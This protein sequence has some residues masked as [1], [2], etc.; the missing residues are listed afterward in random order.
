MPPERSLTDHKAL[1]RRGRQHGRAGETLRSAWGTVVIATVVV[2]ASQWPTYFNVGWNILLVLQG[3]GLALSCTCLGIA[4]VVT[5]VTGRIE[6]FRPVVCASLLLAA[7]AMGGWL[8]LALPAPEGGEFLVI[9]AYAFAAPASSLLAFAVLSPRP[10]DRAGRDAG[11]GARCPGCG[12]DCRTA[13]VR[14]VECGRACAVE[15]L[16]IRRD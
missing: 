8:A 14:C 13:E 9:L 10:G 11:W 15:E 6:L 1:R 5:M 12:Y 2:A 7:A 3:A 4:S 16:R